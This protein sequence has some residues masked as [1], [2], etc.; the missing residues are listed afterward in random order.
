M[1]FKTLRAI[2]NMF[3]KNVFHKHSIIK[4]KER[5]NRMMAGQYSLNKTE[6]QQKD[7]I[8]FLD[9]CPIEYSIYN[10]QNN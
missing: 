5:I 8:R 7:I 10:K 1:H 2:K 4:K 6:E 9:G 3:Y